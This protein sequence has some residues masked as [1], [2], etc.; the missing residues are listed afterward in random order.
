MVAPVIKLTRLMS[1]AFKLAVAM[2]NS[3]FAVNGRFQCCPVC[4]Q[5]QAGASTLLRLI[6]F[7]TSILLAVLL[8]ITL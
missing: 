6:V 1:M 2:Y 7:N 3:P 8:V 5:N 4:N